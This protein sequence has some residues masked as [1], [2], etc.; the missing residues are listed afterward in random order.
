MTQMTN[1]LFEY[2]ITASEARQYEAI[3]NWLHFI[4]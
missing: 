3:I 4:N 2:I 1:S